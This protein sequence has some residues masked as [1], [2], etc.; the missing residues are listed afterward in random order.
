VPGTTGGNGSEL[1]NNLAILIT[2]NTGDPL[3]CP[4]KITELLKSKWF[5]GVLPVT[6]PLAYG[7]PDTFLA[8]LEFIRSYQVQ[9]F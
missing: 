7:F 8:D 3:G 6:A 9:P 2:L 5:C 1:G 4:E